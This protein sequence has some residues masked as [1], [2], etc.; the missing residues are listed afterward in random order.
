LEVLAHLCEQGG[1]P[2]VTYRGKTAKAIAENKGNRIISALL[3]E[4]VTSYL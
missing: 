2:T 3:G 1:D 4:F